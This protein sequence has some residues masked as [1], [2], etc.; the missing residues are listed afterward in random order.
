MLRS[1]LLKS[2]KGKKI[3][4]TGHTGFK[5]SWLSAWLELLGAQVIG[6]SFDIPTQPA[7]CKILDSNNIENYKLDIRNLDSVR[8][9]FRQQSPDYVFHL[10][11]QSLVINSYLNPVDTWSTNLIGTVNILESLK[12]LTTP[13]V[14]VFITSDKCYDNQEW[15]WGYRENDKLGGPDP[16][17]ASKGAAELAIS[18]YFRSFFSKNNFIKLASARAGNVIGGGDW[19]ENRLIPDCI[20]AWSREESVILR[21]PNST[22]PWQH[23]LEPLSGYLSLAINLNL[24]VQLSGKSFNFGPN[25]FST[26]SVLELVKKMSQYWPKVKWSLENVSNDFHESSLLK[27]NCDLAHEVLNWHPKL[28][29]ENTIK[30]TAL[31]YKNYYEKGELNSKEFSLNQINEYMGL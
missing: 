2:F 6:I 3:I 18:S 19:S 15:E 11:A 10:A 5:G 1:Q 25:D 30:M 28:D 23:V 12:S 13:C 21:N 7:H 16:Y 29:F 24:N 4:I 26:K 27:L 17:S 20:R 22:R 9:L 31:W 8:N 14:A